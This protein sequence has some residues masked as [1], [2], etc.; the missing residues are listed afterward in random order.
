MAVAWAVDGA[1]MLAGVKSRTLAMATGE[2]RAEYEDCR[3]TVSPLL[4]CF[5]QVEGSPGQALGAEGNPH[6]GS[7]KAQ[8]FQQ[9]EV[10]GVSGTV[11]IMS[12]EMPSDGALGDL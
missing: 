10:S 12:R 11:P 8:A 6:S 4:M 7:G 9:A 3:H 5:P 1:V 2:I